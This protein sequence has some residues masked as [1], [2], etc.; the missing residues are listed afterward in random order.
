MPTVTIIIPSYNSREYLKCTLETVKKQT[1]QSWECLIIDDCSPDGSADFAREITQDDQRFKVIPLSKNR[2]VSNARNVGLR[3][4]TG[5]Y[6]AFLDADDLW[7]P[8]KL[9]VQLKQ[10]NEKTMQFS[11]TGYSVIAPSGETIVASYPIPRYL[12]LSKFLSN[13]AIVTSSVLIERNL[14]THRFCPGPLFRSEDAIYWIKIFRTGQIALGIRQQLVAYRLTP[15]SLS[16]NKA[17]S[18]L[19]FITISMKYSPYNLPRKV[20]HLIMYTSRAMI[21]HAYFNYCK[22]KLARTLQPLAH[23]LP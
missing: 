14:C 10:M 12:K 20:F 18:F 8:S 3:Q 11:Y 21:K 5:D 16:R 7:H 4:A 17:R 6:I 19:A 22:R 2:G 1:F 9:E 15:G 23:L 13:T